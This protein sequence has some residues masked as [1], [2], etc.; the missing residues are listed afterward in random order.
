VIIID[1]FLDGE[2]CRSIVAQYDAKLSAGE[3]SPNGCGSGREDIFL[4]LVTDGVPDLVDRAKE[5]LSFHLF[6]RP[7]ILDYCAYTRLA[8]GRGHELHA[9]AVKLDGSPNHTADR[10]AT[11]VIYLTHGERDF[12]NGK[13]IFP[14]LG[15]TISARPG[16]LVGF[17]TDLKHQH[18]VTAVSRGSRDAILVWLK[19]PPG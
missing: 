14:E 3:I 13:L 2:L 16:L 1:N 5:L 11:A 17:T 7:L 6:S 12:G 15:V 4:H 8:L 10:V 9:D 18:S 19:Y